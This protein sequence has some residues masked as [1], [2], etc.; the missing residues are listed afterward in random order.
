[1]GHFELTWI[2]YLLNVWMWEVE[3]QINMQIS[4]TSWFISLSASNRQGWDRPKLRKELSLGSHTSGRNPITWIITLPPRVLVAGKLESGTW[5][6]ESNPSSL[7]WVVGIL[8]ARLNS[9]SLELRRA[10]WVAWNR[11]GITE[12][13]TLLHYLWCTF[14]HCKCYCFHEN[15]CKSDPK[16]HLKVRMHKEYNYFLIPIPMPKSNWCLM[17]ECLLTCF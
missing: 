9:H 16:S 12:F 8:I 14:S 4:L 2:I 3:I 7:A 1:M 5:A 15:T 11:A 17:L 6:F 10:R 13:I